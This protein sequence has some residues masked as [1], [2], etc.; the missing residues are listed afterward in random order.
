VATSSWRE[1]F[2]LFKV[3]NDDPRHLDHRLIII[4]THG[5]K[6]TRRRLGK[7]HG[8]KFEARWLEEEACEGIVWT[9]ICFDTRVQIVSFYGPTIEC[10][11]AGPTLIHG[12]IACVL[13]FLGTSVTETN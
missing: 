4:D 6:A 2:P 8:P 9:E 10:R 7:N 5:A 13:R 12:C 11:V 1:R 3:T